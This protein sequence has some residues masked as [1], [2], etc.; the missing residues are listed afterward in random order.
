MPEISVI[1][2][3]FNAQKTIEKCLAS[4]FKQSF[5]DFEIIVVNDGS[6]DQTLPILERYQNKIK[7]VN[8]VNSGAPTARNV[9]AKLA[10]GCYLLFCDADIVLEPTA[11]EKMRQTLKN[12]PDK[13]YV[14]SDFKFGFKK[15]SLFAFDPDKLK[16]MPYI[17]T[18]SLIV[19]KDFPGFDP[20]LKRFQDWDLWLTM[21]EQKKVGVYINKTLF[22]VKSG[23]TMSNWM[24]KIFYRL[25]WLKNVKKYQTAEKIIK[26]KHNL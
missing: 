19:T 6:T 3:A 22:K 16:K 24:P 14:Y 9:G 23:G 8:Q 12:Q 17:H 4:L 7:L 21:L 5:K 18:T 26:D 1:I 25:P 15:F 10:V 20:A 13:S 2:P 11:L